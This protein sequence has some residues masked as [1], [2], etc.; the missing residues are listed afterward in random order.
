M[1]RSNQSERVR[2]MRIREVLQATGLSRSQL[3]KLLKLNEF[4]LPVRL[5]DKPDSR[6][7]AWIES[8]VF[9]WNAKRPKFTPLEWENRGEDMRTQVAKTT[10]RKSKERAASP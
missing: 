9:A 1:K 10:K 7:V 2:L 5:L 4:P 3:Y 6:A 8:E